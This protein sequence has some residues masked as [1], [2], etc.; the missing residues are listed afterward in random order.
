MV[1]RLVPT[2]PVTVTVGGQTSNG[3]TFTVTTA[4]QTFTAATCNQPDVNAVI[5]GPIHTA[6]NDDRLEDAIGGAQRA[7]RGLG[8]L[9]A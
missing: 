2:G 8:K 6:V 5:N 7:R 9:A 3:I 4:T 1:S